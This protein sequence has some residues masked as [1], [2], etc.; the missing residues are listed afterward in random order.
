MAWP[1]VHLAH[2]DPLLVHQVVLIERNH[3]IY[4][5]CNCR[6]K[7]NYTTYSYDPIAETNSIEESRKLY[8]DP[9]NH[10]VK[11]TQEDEAKW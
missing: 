10:W 8:N 3:K 4:V 1:L 7:L 9:A 2:R 5:S 6:E 11:F